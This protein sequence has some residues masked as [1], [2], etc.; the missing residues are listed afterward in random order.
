MEIYLIILK[1]HNIKHVP[2][3]FK[4]TAV[5]KVRARAINNDR[6]KLIWDSV[7]NGSLCIKKRSLTVSTRCASR[8]IDI[9]LHASK[10]KSNDIILVVYIP[11]VCI[12]YLPMKR[13]NRAALHHTY[14]TKRI[15]YA[16]SRHREISRI[17][18]LSEKSR[19]SHS[20]ISIR[21]TVRTAEPRVRRWNYRPSR[22]LRYI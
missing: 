19:S 1:K 6:A 11:D 17:R 7:V 13:R 2:A 15:N 14:I 20:C 3:Q 5:R 22:S 18:R 9:A 8:Y 21:E 10:K 4:C 12:M 16:A